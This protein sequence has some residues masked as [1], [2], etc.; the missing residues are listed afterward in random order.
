MASGNP[1]TDV[2]KLFG[3]AAGVGV[4]QQLASI[5]QELRQLSVV[6]QA[7]V[8]T[9]KASAPAARVESTGSSVARTVTNFF[10]LGLSPLISGIVS[11]FG[12]GGGDN[13]PPPLVPFVAPASVRVNAGVSSSSTGVFAVDNAQ[14]LPRAVPAVTVNVSAMDSRS[15]LDHSH[16]IAAAVRQAMLESTTLNDVIREV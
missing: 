14:N 9:V 3:R 11:L 1:L 15:F 12:G 10:S 5:T 2:S 4:D 6:S 13:E 8:E 16:E 7:V